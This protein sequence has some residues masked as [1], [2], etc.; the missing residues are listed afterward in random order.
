MFNPSRRQA[1]ELFFGTWEKYK[2]G[3]ALEGLETTALEIILL[4]PE[5]Q[6]L[7]S[8]RERNIER[9]Y[10]PESG[11]LNPFLHLSLHLSIAEQLA[12][13]Q[14]AGISEL[15]TALTAKLGDRHAA[16]HIVLE[17]LGETVWQANRSASPPDQDAYLA[18]LRHQLAKD[19]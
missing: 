1:R 13:D 7:L 2:S 17:C 18:C 5:Y 6:A 12:I 9:D 15:F 14:P 10:P 11:G 19:R 4:H 8:D 16:L 3:Q